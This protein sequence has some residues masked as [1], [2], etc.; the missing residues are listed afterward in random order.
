MSN[1]LDRHRELVVATR[2]SGVNRCLERTVR[3]LEGVRGEHRVPGHHGEEFLVAVRLI[4]LVVGIV[5]RF[6]HLVAGVPGRGVDAEGPDVEMAADK[7]E[8]TVVD[9]PVLGVDSGPIGK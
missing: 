2:R 7:V 3:R 4:L 6:G 9:V 5:M 8:V 1:R